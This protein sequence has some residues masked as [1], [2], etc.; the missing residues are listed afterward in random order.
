MP[1]QKKIILYYADWCFHCKTFKEEWAKIKAE[2]K[3]K[4]IKYEEY[5][6]GRNKAEIMSAK[7]KIDGY[8][9]IRIEK[10]PIKYDYEGP[11][12]TKYILKELDSNIDDKT[13]RAL[14]EKIISKGSSLNILDASTKD[15]WATDLADKKGQTGGNY[16][17]EEYKIKY[18]KYKAKYLK[19]LNELSF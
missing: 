19:L 2:C 15:D 12:E 1:E 3:K 14:G 9:T 13:T 11:R 10:G 8:P 5:E 4:G 7:P 18:Y 17:N 16:E 6:D